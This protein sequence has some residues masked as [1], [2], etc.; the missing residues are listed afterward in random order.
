[1]LPARSLRSCRDSGGLP[2]SA[3]GPWVTAP[4]TRPPAET[5][6]DDFRSYMP[7]LLPRFVALLNE[8]ERTSDFSLVGAPGGAV[9]KACWRGRGAARPSSA[10]CMGRP[11]GRACSAPPRLEPH[12][13]VQSALTRKL[14]WLPAACPPCC[15]GEA[16]AGGDPSPRAGVGGPPAAAA[17]R[18]QPADC[19]RGERAAACDTRGNAGD[20]AGGGRFCRGMPPAPDAESGGM[21]ARSNMSTGMAREWRAGSVQALPRGRCVAVTRPPCPRRPAG[22]AS[23]HAAG[24]LQLRGAAPAHPPAGRA[25]R[26]AARACAGHAVLRQ[27]GHWPRLCHLCAHNQEGEGWGRVMGQVRVALQKLAAQCVATCVCSLLGPGRVANAGHHGIARLV[28]AAARLILP[29]L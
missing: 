5:L 28:C 16:R 9:K 14:P 27:P 2:P 24:R 1:M 18:A 12:R 20:H 3:A 10:V 11:V 29:V 22:P 4:P 8:A 13:G 21:P 19:S 15:A 7:E 17:A 6:R 23:S 26:G 25:R